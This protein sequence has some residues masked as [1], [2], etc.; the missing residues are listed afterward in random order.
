MKNTDKGNV[1][2]SGR[3]VIGVYLE[4]DYKKIL[5]ELAKKNRR[6]LSAEISLILENHLMQEKSEKREKGGK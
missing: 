6:S 1:P 4:D 2:A 5:M 3:T